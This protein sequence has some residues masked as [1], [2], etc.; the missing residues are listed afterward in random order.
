M[1]LPVEMSLERTFDSVGDKWEKKGKQFF[2][3]VVEGYHKASRLDRFQGR[4]GTIDA[5]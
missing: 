5:V 3:R 1:E 4:W 2:E